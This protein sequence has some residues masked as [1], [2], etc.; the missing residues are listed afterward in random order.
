[1]ESDRT[2]LREK[3]RVGSIARADALAT[4]V[5]VPSGSNA[6]ES[7]TWKGGSL[8]HSRPSRTFSGWASPRVPS[9]PE[10]G[11]PPYREAQKPSWGSGSAREAQTCFMLHIDHFAST[12][13]SLK[14][15]FHDPMTK[16]ASRA[17]I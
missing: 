5:V 2:S 10:P 14:A 12:S 15:L 16:S 4:P 7:A 1:M 6:V 3:V 11:E 17:M 13:Y 8:E 9:C